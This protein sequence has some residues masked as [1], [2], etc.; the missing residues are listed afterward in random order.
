MLSATAR[1]ILFVFL[2]LASAS[3]APFNPFPGE[4]WTSGSVPLDNGGDALF[5]YLFRART[6]ASDQRSL[7]IWLNGG[8]GC[9][10]TYGLFSENGPYLFNKS[11]QLYRNPFAWNQLYDVVFVDQ[12]VG[13]MY[14][15]VKDQAHYCRNETCVARGFYTFLRGFVELYPEYRGVP[16][17]LT[18]ESYAGHYIPAITAYLARSANRDVINLKA[19]AIGN[20]MTD[21]QLQIGVYPDYVFEEGKLSWP[22][23]ALFKVAALVCQTALQSGYR[24]FDTFCINSMAAMAIVA[25]ITNYYDIRRTDKDDAIDK[26][27]L[28]ML[29]DSTV[30][31]GFGVAPRIIPAMCD[32]TVYQLL[33]NDWCTP[34]TRDI[35]YAVEHGVRIML[36]YGDKDYI[37]NWRGG[38]ALARNIEWVGQEE[39]RSAPTKSVVFE[40]KPHGEF[41]RVG[42]FTFMRVYDAGHMVPSDQPGFAQNLLQ[43]FVEDAIR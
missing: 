39:Y 23:Y 3:A 32:P 38:E 42:N 18:G 15:S 6:P 26:A 4:S 12:P 40:G 22:L 21:V 35:A 1:V 25:N 24:S 30:Q 16:L 36:F 43:R 8:P 17:F 7:V 37:C 20:G 27:I 28:K 9:S 14:A 2:Y 31:R 33:W 41:R 11:Q 19:S 34:V 29:N 13:T 5:Y 10:S